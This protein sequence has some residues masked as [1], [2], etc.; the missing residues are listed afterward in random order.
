MLT[1][2]ALSLVIL[3]LRR[4]IVVEVGSRLAHARGDQGVQVELPARA[5]L[6]GRIGVVEVVGEAQFR[7]AVGRKTGPAKERYPG[8]LY[9]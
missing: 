4:V 8:W 6:T 3:L 2:S 9:A 7:D 5:D 1:P